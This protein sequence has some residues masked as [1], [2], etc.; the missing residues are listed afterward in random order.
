MNKLPHCTGLTNKAPHFGVTFP[1][2]VLLA[3]S[4]AGQIDLRAAPPVPDVVEVVKKIDSLYRAESS[5][6]KLDMQIVTS[7]YER[8]LSMEV[9]TSGLEKTF[10]RILRPLK[11]KDV[12]TLRIGNE[13]WNFLPKTNKVVKIPPSMMMS[14]WMGSDFTNDDLVKESSFLDDYHFSLFNP[15]DAQ[16][17]L[18]YVRCIPREGLPVVWAEVIIAVN[19]NGFVPVWQHFLDERGGLIRTLNYSEV[20]DLGGRR[21]PSVLEMIPQNR[22][23]QKTVIRYLELKFNLPLEDDLFSLRNLRSTP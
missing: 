14:S 21:I 18:I 13:M 17:D 5:F 9:W 4:I 3:A 7:H 10:I 23:D 12:A 11:E 20:K 6:G 15:P 1:A 2:A 22:P 16:P 8:T 19:P